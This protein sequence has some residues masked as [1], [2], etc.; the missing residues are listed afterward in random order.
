MRVGDPGYYPDD[1]ACGLADCH[2]PID[3]FSNLRDYAGMRWAERPGP[4]EEVSRHFFEWLAEHMT[5]PEKWLWTGDTEAA[6]SIWRREDRDATRV[7][8]G[9]VACPTR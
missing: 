9:T 3:A 5:E 6:G 7:T 1:F 8:R 4:E 2:P